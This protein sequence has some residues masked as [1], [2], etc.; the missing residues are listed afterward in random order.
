MELKALWWLHVQFPP[1]RTCQPWAWSKTQTAAAFLPQGRTQIQCQSI[2]PRW[3][4]RVNSPANQVLW[5]HREARR[6]GGWRGPGV[7]GEHRAM[8]RHDVRVFTY[9][10]LP[11]SHKKLGKAHDP[12]IVPWHGAGNQGSVGLERRSRSQ[13]RHRVSQTLGPVLVFLQQ[14]AGQ[15][16]NDSCHQVQSWGVGGGFIY[17]LAVP[18]GPPPKTDSLVNKQL[19]CNPGMPGD[20]VTWGHGHS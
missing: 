15:D 6:A 12:S 5:A 18:A 17:S 1:S 7:R 9:S 19:A 2:T 13:K 14:G 16:K 11:P 4:R 10:D 20:G 3:E 8:P